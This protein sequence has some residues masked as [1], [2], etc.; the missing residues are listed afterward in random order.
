MKKGRHRKKKEH[1]EN[2]E[3][4]PLSPPRKITLADS[5]GDPFKQPCI[6]IDKLIDTSP[7]DETDRS[8][9]KNGL[10][11]FY[12]AIQLLLKDLENNKDEKEC[13][14]TS[15]NFVELTNGWHAYKTDLVASLKSPRRTDFI[16]YVH[17][18]LLKIGMRVDNLLDHPP[19]TPQYRIQGPKLSE[20][21][22]TQTNDILKNF[23]KLF[24]HLL[25]DETVD[26]NIIDSARNPLRKFRQELLTKYQ[27]F[28][29]TESKDKPNEHHSQFMKYIDRILKKTQ[30]FSVSHNDSIPAPIQSIDR[31]I[32]H[33]QKIVAKG[34]SQWKPLKLD[35]TTE[36]ASFIRSALKM[37]FDA[38]SSAT[39]LSIMRFSCRVSE[40]LS[41]VT[42][43]NN[44]VDAQSTVSSMRD[45][46]RLKAPWFK[47]PMFSAMDGM[48][49]RN[50]ERAAMIAARY[51]ED[52]IEKEK[53]FVD[54][55]GERDVII[56][57][58]KNAE[59]RT[60][61]TNER[62]LQQKQKLESLKSKINS[63]PGPEIRFHSE[64]D[65]IKLIQK[66]SKHLSNWIDDLNNEKAELLKND[67]NQKTLGSIQ[68]D[69]EI[70]I[71]QSIYEEHEKIMKQIKDY[72]KEI[73]ILK[74]ENEEIEKENYEKQGKCNDLSEKVD[75]IAEKVSRFKNK[76]IKKNKKIEWL[77]AEIERLKFE[78]GNMVE[79][80][81]KNKQKYETKIEEVNEEIHKLSKQS[82]RL[83]KVLQETVREKETLENE[84]IPD[85]EYQIERRAEICQYQTHQAILQKNSLNLLKLQALDKEL[86]EHLF[87]DANETE[88]S[89][90]EQTKIPIND[91]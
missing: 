44:F 63:I 82:H 11:S 19:I 28:F 3:D 38:T 77:N 56:Q 18:E 32:I 55:Y 65:V 76:F 17:T 6:Q 42:G 39:G 9:L 52:N 61:Q 4:V 81:E 47:E 75:I 15:V 8:D 58:I 88:N 22:I 24:D 59:I 31:S 20:Q 16:N 48:I 70:A 86:K 25:T 35:F 46:V 72:K 51:T 57:Q 12:E 10:I 89:I 1:K 90:N 49:T 36:S 45:K 60:S 23:R 64:N 5:F 85:L 66:L 50:I 2:K 21:I 41:Q 14:I 62:H 40:A 73:A 71:T 78:N 84:T 67:A 53:D 91:E 13:K 33:L 29:L 68:F 74:L 69:E 79:I 37:Q 80:E 34:D 26:I 30:H 54:S 43:L 83:P 27:I 87:N 7:M